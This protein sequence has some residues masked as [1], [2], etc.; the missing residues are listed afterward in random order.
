MKKSAIFLPDY[1]LI[2]KEFLT[3]LKR[4]GHNRQKRLRNTCIIDVY[5]FP[6][7]ASYQFTMYCLQSKTL[8][9]ILAGWPQPLFE[10][11]LTVP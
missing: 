4:V 2:L 10:A 1:I 7:Y 8:Y 5:V 11:A 3:I 9:C 6:N